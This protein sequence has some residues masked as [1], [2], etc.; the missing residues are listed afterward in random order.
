M[1]DK[2]R[3]LLCSHH[4]WSQASIGWPLWIPAGTCDRIWNWGRE[5]Q[6]RLHKAKGEAR[7]NP[8][9]LNFLLFLR[10][11]AQKVHYSGFVWTVVQLSTVPESALRQSWLKTQYSFTSHLAKFLSLSS[12]LCVSPWIK[13]TSV[14]IYQLS[15]N[16]QDMG[17]VT[18][19]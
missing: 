14:V 9:L 19:P 7:Q 17:V 18:G 16:M 8:H 5:W 11:L 1:L 10:V 4:L 3:V 12:I 6:R 13:V 15:C 2:K